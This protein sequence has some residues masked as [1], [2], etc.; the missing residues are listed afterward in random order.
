[1]KH[2]SATDIANWLITQYDKSAGDVVTHL[3]IQKL[4]YYA[5]A[6]SLV[7]ADR[8]L[9]RENIEAWAHGPVV[10]EVFNEFRHAGWQAL[11]ATRPP[12]ELDTRTED[13]LHQ[14]LAAYG[15][16]SAKTLESMTHSDRPWIQAR[17][18]LPAEARCTR[19]ISNEAIKTY[20]LEKYGDRLDD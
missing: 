9:I 12:I 6:W 5:H 10:R 7:L 15:D 4:I 14:V 17:G 19:V 8:P 3:K 13:I 20:F 16:T 2:Y 11:D 18:G 1:M